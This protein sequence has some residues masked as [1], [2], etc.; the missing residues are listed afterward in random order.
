[1][2]IPLARVA[3]LALRVAPLVAM[4]GC[5]QTAWQATPGVV[6]PLSTADQMMDVEA[7]DRIRRFQRLSAMAGIAPPL[8]QQALV[9][10]SEVPG[11]DRPIP[12]IRVV[13]DEGDFFRSGAFMPQPQ[14]A[15]IL[16]VIAENMR[17]DVPDVRLTVLGHTDAVGS[18][19]SNI[20]L[21]KERAVTVM[22][23]L[24]QD[25]A[26][27][28]Q[29]GTVAIGRA[30]PIAPNDTSAGRARNRRVEFLISP[31][32]AANLE[33]VQDRPINP[34]YFDL[35][36]AQAATP[37]PPPQRVAFLKPIYSGPADFSEATVDRRQIRLATVRQ[38]SSGN[39]VAG[40]SGSPVA[41][42]ANGA[43]GMV[44]AGVPG[45][46][47]GDAGLVP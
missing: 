23:L 25:G 7:A 45:S 6:A 20:A 8:F 30:Q 35:G 39:A 42:P 16:Q 29:L 9:P 10:A 27:P 12:V 26:N 22:Q 36:M 19:A 5:A 21:S 44:G 33:V 37:R 32:E 43:V 2:Q 4:G 1:L 11:A 41:G 38:I 34:A 14:A 28:G 13:F 47:P 40:A 46:G 24:I 31:S 18:D 17:N 15:A 3:G